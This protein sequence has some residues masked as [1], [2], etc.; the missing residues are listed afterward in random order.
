MPELA[1]G[2][3][4][5]VEGTCDAFAGQPAGETD[6]ECIDVDGVVVQVGESFLEDIIN[7]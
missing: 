2:D 6:L 3:I 5:N 7:V 1:G 4:I